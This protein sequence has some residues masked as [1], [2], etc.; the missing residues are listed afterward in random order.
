MPR[1]MTPVL[2]VLVLAA[3]AGAYVFS[4]ELLGEND[5]VSQGKPD[6]GPP[7]A[8][9]VTLEATTLKPELTRIEAVGTSRAVRSVTLHPAASGEVVAVDFSAGQ[10]V[11]GGQVLVKLDDRDAA[12]AL[13]LA[14]VRVE[15]AQR[16]LERYRRTRGSGAVSPTMLDD[17]RTH[18]ATARIERDRAQV[19]L[20]D[21]TIKAPFAGY[22]GITEVQPGD[23]VAEDTVIT[24]LDE[25][26]QL[27]V[28]FEVPEL[29]FDRLELGQSLLVT[30]WGNRG[31]ETQGQIAEI[32]SR[33]D[34]VSRT[35][36]VRARVA[37]PEDR[38][39]PGMSFRVIL[40]LRG[41]V[42]PVVPEVAVQWGGE[43]SYVW[44][45]EE[46]TV[47]RV[48]VTIVQRQEGR[49]L[50]DGEL[51]AGSRVVVE[52]VQRMR[53]GTRISQYR[54]EALAGTPLVQR[55]QETSP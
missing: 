12:L 46:D 29:F 39:R 51:P 9:P 25:R 20:E 18:L 47:R 34:P 15:D 54:E 52:G 30:S 13:E 44:L 1:Y 27:L 31:L 16:L 41:P 26:S 28:N 22:V 23:R 4:P 55:H 37:N 42:F 33:I 45:V 5:S 40:N 53:E 43:G 49:V 36:R 24:T 6:Q 10:R 35:F 21:R 50:V 48:G 38:L 14:R 11:E 7:P 2:M 3:A 8:I 19:A 32:G 17:A